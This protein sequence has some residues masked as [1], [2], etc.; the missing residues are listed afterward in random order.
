MRNADRVKNIVAVAESNPEIESFIVF[1][2]SNEEE[3]PLQI[4]NCQETDI[5]EFI[6]FITDSMS[7]KGLLKIK[8]EI[9]AKVKFKTENMDLH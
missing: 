8:A 3:N 4:I 7:Q 5:M 2:K 9:E 1:L 6:K